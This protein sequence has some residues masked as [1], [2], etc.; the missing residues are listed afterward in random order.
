MGSASTKEQ[1]M[2][3]AAGSRGLLTDV[4]GRQ[5]QG[6]DHQSLLPPL[7]DAVQDPALEKQYG[8]ALH[9]RFLPSLILCTH[10]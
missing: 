8:E 9:C 7:R 5:P 3:R 10:M 1:C 2:L 4:L 6:L